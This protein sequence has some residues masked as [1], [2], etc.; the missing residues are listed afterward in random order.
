MRGTAERQR[1]TSSWPFSWRAHRAFLVL[2]ALA[3]PLT[4]AF[5]WQEVL[6]TLSDDSVSYLTLARRL[7]PFSADPLSAPWA[8]YYS[9]YPPLFPLVLALTGGAQDFLTAHLG[10]GACALL[11]LPL[12][13]RHA[14]LRLGSTG[15][16]VLLALLF[17]MSPSAWISILGILSEPLYLFLSLAALAFHE[18]RL[19]AN[20]SSADYLTFGFLMAA[21][22]LTRSAGVAL[23]VA[24]ALH[25]AVGA[26]GRRQRPAPSTL[27]ALAPVLALAAL[28][29][30]LRPTPEADNY[31]QTFQFL[32]QRWSSETGRLFS[33]SG[34]ALFGGWVSSFSGDSQVRPAVQL[35]FGALGFLGIAGA[36]LGALRNR[37]DAWYVLASLAMTLL[38]V[39]PEDNMRRLLYPL[40]PLLLVHAGEALAA[41]CA[42]F[43]AL[44]YERRVLLFGWALL[45]AMVLPASLLIFEKALDRAPLIAGLAYSASSI[46]EY[47]TT[48]NV[49]RARAM[50]LRQAA[51][52]G[53]LE[54]LDRATPPGSR[55]MWMRPEYVALL[56]KRMGVP[57]YFRWDR[58]TLAREIRRSDTGYLVAAAQ[59]KTDLA[60]EYGD[61]FAALVVEPP[62]YLRRI[63][64]MPG[65]GLGGEIFVLFEVDRAALDLYLARRS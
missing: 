36:L 17:L 35:A 42:R 54:A 6:A 22:F 31:R 3:T 63:P 7:S 61:A 24:Y 46:T 5:C 37:L 8:K 20:G 65:P 21:A 25:V 45:A 32:L 60:G 1:P 33:L 59:F 64:V 19:D 39:F 30:A 56:G 49:A 18:W 51:V 41:A 23:I 55:V 10:V 16:G 58:A 40:L 15:A 57:W 12:V 13:Y 38:W 4:I 9:H 43:K 62:D 27:I 28:W 34:D 50:A 52:L 26:I 14:A 2:L 48:V 53:G 11:A 29:L 44:R 47:Y